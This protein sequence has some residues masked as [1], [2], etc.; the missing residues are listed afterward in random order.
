MH[1][2]TARTNHRP[3]HKP[4]ALG[5]L[6]LWSVVAMQ[7][8]ATPSS[9]CE[10]ALVLPLEHSIAGYVAAQ[11]PERYAIDV[12]RS[13]FLIIE[14]RG[15]GPIPLT[16]RF[17]GRDCS[18]TAS[19]LPVPII[20]GRHLH[21]VKDPGTYFVEI[22]SADLGENYQLYAW[23]VED[24]TGHDLPNKE[25]MA[26][27]DELVGCL[28]NKEEMAEAD[29]L[30]GCLPNKEE[31]AEADELVGCLPNKEEM[32]EAEELVGRRWQEI[33][34]H[35]L[36]EIAPAP[37]GL[38]T[39]FHSLCPWARRP[40]LLRT[41]TCA[42]RLRL[43]ATGMV[44]VTPPAGDGTRLIGVTLGSAGSLAIEAVGDPSATTVVFNAE[45]GPAG[46]LSDHAAWLEAGD[47]VFET[48]AGD[49]PIRIYA[50]LD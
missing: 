9:A 21:R 19:N 5:M 4:T 44:T 18:I 24:S 8:Q 42:P 34:G 13:G 32:A 16:V 12:E 49:G 47:Y 38:V 25:E 22:E 45:G 27:A 7:L 33:A 28:P 39:R 36:V 40:G 48:T 35:G 3:I 37:R 43:D 10:E 23:W 46:E 17:L 1:P 29:E 41:L 31:M 14:A 6:A 20:Q 11:R 26:E 30:V 50:E 2:F 15:T